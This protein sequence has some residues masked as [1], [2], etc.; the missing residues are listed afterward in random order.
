[1]AMKRTGGPGGP[2]VDDDDDESIRN[3]SSCA[4][5]SPKLGK[6]KGRS[7]KAK[8]AGAITAAARA[9]YRV[10]KGPK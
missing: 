8:A 3:K 7:A 5:T 6:L 1:M 2:A 10:A 4:S 9:K